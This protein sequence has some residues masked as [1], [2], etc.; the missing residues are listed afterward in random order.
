MTSTPSTNVAWPSL[1][2]S[3]WT[4]TKDTLHMWTQIVGKVR[5]AL[6]PHVNHW[7]NVTLY[8]TAR[9]LT[10]SAMPYR[11]GTV[12]MSFDFIDEVMRVETSDGAVEE[13]ALRPRSVADFYH[14]TMDRLRKAGVDVHIWPHPVE[15][16]D[17]IPFAKDETHGSYDTDAVRRLSLVLAQSSHVMQKFRG[18]FIGK[19][20]P[21]HFWWGSFDLACTRFSGRPAPRHPGGIPNCPDY[22][23]LEAYSHECIS[24]GWWPGGGAV[25]DAAFYAYAYPEPDGC[26]A[27]PLRPSAA[28]YHPVMHEWVLPY[29][30]VRRSPTPEADLLAFLES[31]YDAPATLGKWDRAALEVR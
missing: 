17:P 1:R 14:A 20:S 9:G 22:V 2:L 11:G 24:A 5:L 28:T 13:V 4:D 15:I 25:D 12:E 10:T 21:V 16:T 3:E 6:T 30:S 23:T 8:V 26:S 18:R 7:W 27:A 19:C 31:A 29:E